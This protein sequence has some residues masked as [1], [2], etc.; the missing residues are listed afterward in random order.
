[1]FH[2]PHMNKSNGIA[3]LSQGLSVL[4]SCYSCGKARVAA[5]ITAQPVLCCGLQLAPV[6]TVSAEGIV[7][8]TAQRCWSICVPNMSC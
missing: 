2:I 4:V 1:M 3:V 8:C 5:Q 7:L 6:T